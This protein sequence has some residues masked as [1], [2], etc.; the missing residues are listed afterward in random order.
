MNAWECAPVGLDGHRWPCELAGFGS[1]LKPSRS[2]IPTGAQCT[3]D[4][5]AA[6]V[7]QADPEKAIQKAIRLTLARC[8]A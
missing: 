3:H 8:H 6:P 4:S 2:N 7:A 5:C 1:G